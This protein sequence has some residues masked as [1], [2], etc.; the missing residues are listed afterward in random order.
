ME[1]KEKR[2]KDLLKYYEKRGVNR[3]SINKV[4]HKIIA[5]KFNKN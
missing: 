2:A 3:E 1:D 5:I 4:Y